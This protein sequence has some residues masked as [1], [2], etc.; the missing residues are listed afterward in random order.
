MRSYEARELRERTLEGAG[1]GFRLG[2]ARL[3]QFA[4]GGGHVHLVEPLIESFEFGN[5]ELLQ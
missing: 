1:E 2:E 5:H 4:I 3:G